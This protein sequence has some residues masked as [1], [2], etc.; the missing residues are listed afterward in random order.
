[1]SIVEGLRSS[2]VCFSMS[3]VKESLSVLDGSRAGG[4]LVKGVKKV[5]RE[6]THGFLLGE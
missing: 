5:G 6:Y 2:S 1:M 3:S 4:A